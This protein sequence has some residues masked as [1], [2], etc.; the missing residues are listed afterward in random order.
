MKISSCLN[1][2]IVLFGIGNEY[3]VPYKLVNTN[4]HHFLQ[5]ISPKDM[6]ITMLKE[7]TATANPLT[8]LEFVQGRS[9]VHTMMDFVLTALCAASKVKSYS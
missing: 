8:S 1:F 6:I 2:V 9:N 5:L 3:H 7:D 4:L